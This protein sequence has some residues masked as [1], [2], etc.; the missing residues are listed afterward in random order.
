MM[1]STPEHLEAYMAQHPSQKLGGWKNQGPV[2]CL[3]QLKSYQPLESVRENPPQIPVLL[4]SGSRDAVCPSHVIEEVHGLLPQSRIIT[5]NASHL[6]IMGPDHAPEVG[7][8]MAK[9]YAESFR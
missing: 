1:P 6:E 9:F 4:I 5:R 3:F 7:M 2:R 8:E